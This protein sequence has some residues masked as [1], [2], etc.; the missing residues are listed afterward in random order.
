MLKPGQALGRYELIIEAARGGMGQVWAARL[1]GARGF[2][3][4][5]AIKTLLP[6]ACGDAERMLLSEARLAALV[7]HPNVVVTHE[8]G[9]HE[10]TLFLVM[11]WIDGEPLSFVLKQAALGGGVPLP[12]AVNLVGQVLRGLHAAHELRDEADSP[13]GVVHRDVSPHNVLLTYSGVAKLVDFGIAKATRERAGATVTGE[14]KGKFAYMAPE[15]ILGGEVDRRADIFATGILLYLLSTGRHP[16]RHHDSAGVLHSITSD[17]PVSPPSLPHSEYPSGLAGVV[18]KALERDPRERWATAEDMRLA[19]QR[20]LPEALGES[21]E[22]LLPQ[23]TAEVLGARATARR[24]ALRRLIAAADA[25]SAEQRRVG[26][27]AFAVS[28]QSGGSLKAIL[29][30]SDAEELP[31]ISGRQRVRVDSDAPTQSPRRGG[32]RSGAVLA[33][34]A[35][36]GLVGLGWGAARGFEY[37]GRGSGSAAAGSVAA[38]EVVRQAPP[39]PTPPAPPKATLGLESASNAGDGAT[40]SASAAPTP[41]AVGSARAGSKPRAPTID[42]RRKPDRLAPP[43]ATDLLSPY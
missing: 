10:G 7:Q 43:P 31:Q 15:Q 33:A 37:G 23:W 5:V 16:F 42:K 40:T 39:F 36:L 17:E 13:L 24:N 22:Q 18:M 35:C 11:E 30:E 8:L 1:R 12:V 41:P 6:L 14:I 19:L 2:Q 32:V 21:A 9:D 3:K 25:A 4:L 27:G 38:A 34:L 28:S 26:S 20:A 29:L